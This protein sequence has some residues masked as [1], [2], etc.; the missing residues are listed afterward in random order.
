MLLRLV[1]GACVAL[2]RSRKDSPAELLPPRQDLFSYTGGYSWG[3]K[4]SGCQNLAYAIVGRVY[5][6]DNLSSSELTEKA[7][8]ILDVL[9]STLI[10]DDEYTLDVTIIRQSLGDTPRKI[11]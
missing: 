2:W 5:E 11:F 9:I 8:K 3:Y 10:Q 6:Y 1:E 7:M 4:G